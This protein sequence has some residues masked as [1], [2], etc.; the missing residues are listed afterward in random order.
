M[1]GRSWCLGPFVSHL[2]LSSSKMI[3]KPEPGRWEGSRKISL[4][5]G[6]WSFTV[7]MSQYGLFLG[8]TAR[9]SIGRSD[10]VSSLG[11]TKWSSRISCMF[12]RWSLAGT[13]ETEPIREVTRVPSPRVP[14]C[15][16]GRRMSLLI[17]WGPRHRWRPRGPMLRRSGAL[18]GARAA[19][20]SRRPTC[21]PLLVLRTKSLQKAAARKGRQAHQTGSGQLS[22]IIYDK[23]GLR[24]WVGPVWDGL[25]A[26]SPLSETLGTRSTLM[27]RS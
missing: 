11:S 7:V 6:T 22:H 8:L 2:G 17:L 14:T 13:N 24:A 1:R 16:G 15:R 25:P 9:T 12:G 18:P 20:E 5:H 21:G 19:A 10:V 3:E 27:S 4:T 23:P 26:S